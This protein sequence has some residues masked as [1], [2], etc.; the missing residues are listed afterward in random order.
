[1]FIKKIILCNVIDYINMSM[2]NYN[3]INSS[4]EKLSGQWLSGVSLIS[5]SISRSIYK[6][7]LC[8]CVHI[9]IY[10]LRFRNHINTGYIYKILYLRQA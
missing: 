10:N 8:N 1:M 6:C 3:D 2:Y 7:V 4:N 9:T 5:V